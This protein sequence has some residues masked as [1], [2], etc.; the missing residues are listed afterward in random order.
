MKKTTALKNMIRS[1]ELSFIMEAHDGISSRIVEEAGF[2]GIW[3]S[4]LSISASLGVRDNNE[5][6][7]TQVLEVLDFM[8]DAVN[9]P[10]LFDADTGYGNFNNVRRLVKK[11]EQRNIAGM[12]IEDKVFPKTNSFIRSESQPLADI[13]EFCGKIKAAADM[14]GDK[15]FVIA[16]RTEAFIAGYGLGEAL[17]RAEA[18]KNAGADAILVHSKKSNPSEIEEFT[19]FWQNKLPVIAVPTKYYSTPAEKF[20][21]MNISLVIW[22]NHM[23]RAAVSGMQKIARLVKNDCSLVNV[24]DDIATVAEIFRR[25]GY[26]E[27][28]EAEKKYLPAAGKNF[29]AIILAA[30]R[31]NLGELTEKIPKTLLKIEGKT[32]LTSAID[33]FNCLGIK[34]ITVVRGFAK[35]LVKPAGCNFID[36]DDFAK[37]NEVYSLYLALDDIRENTIICY[38][39]IVFKSYVLNELINDPNEI[40]LI[41]DADFEYNARPEFDYVKTDSS[42][43]KKLF[44]SDV[45]F[46]KMSPEL[47]REEISGEFI[48]IIKVS[49]GGA[50]LM[51]ETIKKASLI[52]GFGRLGMHDILN[53]IA[54]THP[55]Y[56]KFIKGS[57]LNVNTVIDLQKTSKLQEI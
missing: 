45:K 54:K 16:A 12:C 48:G 18:Y 51:R 11:L 10:I 35:D 43:S 5:A 24:E 23:I 21:E 41:V 28:R 2:A 57:W 32:I 30:A 36:N 46:V 25:E 13:E 27:L 39:D 42:Y 6:S 26:D 47:Q 49:G 15:D 14:R 8:N 44:S 9:I 19:N 7:W 55:V 52:D 31:G 38:G 53:E 4:S 37:T 33:N 40:T 34:D 1:G 3:A 20:R 22:A 29:N 50:S 17:K 56:V